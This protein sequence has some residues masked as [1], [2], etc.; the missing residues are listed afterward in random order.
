MRIG[1][2]GSGNVGRTLGGRWALAG[3]EVS[4]GVR[5]P[6]QKEAQYGD[7]AWGGRAAF[8]EVPRA[9]EFA[10]VVVFAVPS[11]AVVEIGES[12]QKACGEKV[13][14]DATNDFGREDP[15]RVLELREIAPGAQ[16]FRAFNSLG[17]EVFANPNFDGEPADLF[18]CG[19]EDGEGVTAVEEL[20][21]GQG[22]RPVR[23]VGAHQLSIVNNLGRLWLALA[24]EA[25]EGRHLAFKV[26]G[27]QELGSAGG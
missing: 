7:E 27:G 23:I 12:N 26:L 1:M 10:Q 14:I 13:L 4:F 17:W 3:H 25:G 20:I 2:I 24:L 15:S 22:L 8:V 18:Y 16:V 11:E 9:I 19:P 6:G 5:N 21:E